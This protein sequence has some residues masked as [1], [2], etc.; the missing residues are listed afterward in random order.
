MAVPKSIIF[1]VLFLIAG[2][3]LS[4]VWVRSSRGGS[5]VEL[6]LDHNTAASL[7]RMLRRRGVGGGGGSSDCAESLG[8]LS[9]ALVISSLAACFL[10]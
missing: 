1:L 8:G 2:A 9:L 6:H 4:L 5:P 10:I 7:R 3:T